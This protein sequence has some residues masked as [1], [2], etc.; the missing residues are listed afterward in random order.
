MLSLIPLSSTGRSQAI[1]QHNQHSN[2]PTSNQQMSINF[3]FMRKKSRVKPRDVPPGFPCKVLG[4]QHFQLSLRIQSLFL[5]GKK[6]FQ[7]TCSQKNI[8][9]YFNSMSL[10]RRICHQDATVLCFMIIRPVRSK[11]EGSHKDKVNASAFH[12]SALQPTPSY[13]NHNV[14][15]VQDLPRAPGPSLALT[16]SIEPTCEISEKWKNQHVVMAMEPVGLTCHADADPSSS[17]ALNL[18]FSTERSIPISS[19]V[20]ASFDTA[21]LYTLSRND[22]T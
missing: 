13:Q 1:S 7:F 12:V 3:V 9:I 2:C 21:T 18:G 5:V 11:A 15:I 8:S 19:A 14:D 10:K 20:V 17:K 22:L 16:D 6:L 4:C